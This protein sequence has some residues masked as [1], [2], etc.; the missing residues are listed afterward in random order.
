[1]SRRLQI[2]EGVLDVNALAET[3][4]EDAGEEGEEQAGEADVELGAGRR[5]SR[6]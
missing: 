2:G 6:R 4:E 3:H 1:M 5:T